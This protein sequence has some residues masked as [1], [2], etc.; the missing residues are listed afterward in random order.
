MLIKRRQRA[1]AQAQLLV[2]TKISTML[3]MGNTA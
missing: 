1:Q 3:G 2:E